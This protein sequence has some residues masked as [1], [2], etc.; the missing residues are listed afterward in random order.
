GFQV[1]PLG[2]LLKNKLHFSA[3]DLAV[4]SLWASIPGYFS[5]AFGMVRDSW[6][7][8]GL[9]DR[10]YLILFGLLEALAFLVFAFVPPTEFELLLV[11]ILTSFFFLFTWGAW[12]GLGS[13]IG[14]QF[15]MSGQISALWNFLGTA[16][17]FVG[18]FSSGFLS[19]WL[20]TMNPNDAIRVLFLSVSAVMLLI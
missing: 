7:P 16:T 6:N 4:F 15:A 20:E 12:N 14:Q 19:D 2:F 17:I 1:I 3:P 11:T 10:G 8:F 5:F 18:V 9:G 13:V